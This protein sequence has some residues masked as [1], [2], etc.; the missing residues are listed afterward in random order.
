[1]SHLHPDT[2]ASIALL[3]KRFYA[4]VT[5]PHTWRM[6]FLRYFT[7]QSFRESSHPVASSD[8]SVL[9][10][11]R[12]DTRHFCR[13]TA[14]A[15]WRSEYILRT[16]LLRSLARGK[17]DLT[18]G[19]NTPSPGGN[20]ASGRKQ[21]AI[22]TYSSRLPGLV[23]NIH[24]VF[25]TGKKSPRAILG[26]SSIGAATLS[27]PSSGKT[28]KWVL[29]PPVAG[30]Q[31]I[32]QFPHVVPYGV[33]TG[34]A[35]SPNVMEVSLP[36]GMILGEGLPG[37]RAFFRAINGASGRYLGVG[38][39]I[40]N[41]CPAIP[42]VPQALEA[43]S[44]LWLAKSNAVPAATLSMC[45]IFTGSTLGIVTA[46]ALDGGDS[47]GPRKYGDGDMSARWLLSPGVPI[48]ALQVDEEYSWKR[49][50]SSRVWAVALNALGEVYYLTESPN[51]AAPSAGRLHPT[52][53][54]KQAWCAGQSAGWRLVE[55]TRR[56]SRLASG[57]DGLDDGSNSSSSRPRPSPSGHSKPGLEQ[58]APEAG[59]AEELLRLPPAYFR[60]RFLGWD[61]QRRLE[62][63]FA[64]GDDVGA[65]EAVFVVD[66]G[67]AGDQPA[68]IRRFTRLP[69][70]APDDSSNS[71]RGLPSGE[72]PISSDP[73][74]AQPMSSS[75]PA[76]ACHHP[77]PEKARHRQRA[78]VPAW[79]CRP[80]A[81]LGKHSGAVISATG[82]DRS[83]QSLLT[84]AEDPL[85]VPSTADSASQLGEI[86]GRRGR[87]VA[88]GTSTGAV[89]IWNG[90]DCDGPD[91][92]INPLRIIQTDS[93][94]VSCLSLSALYLVHGGSDGLL[95]AWD[96]L[97]SSLEPIRT[98]HARPRG[99][100]ARPSSAGN[101]HVRVGAIW[102]DADATQL[103]GVATVGPL[104]RYW[105]FGSSSTAP[106]RRRRLRHGLLHGR[107]VS[108]RSGGAVAD[109]I[110]AEEAEL[111][112]E[113][114]QRSRDRRR[115]QS[116]FGVGALGD[117]TDDEALLYAQMVSHEAY[118]RD[119]RRRAQVS[120]PEPS[121]PPAA[122][123]AVGPSD[124]PPPPPPPNTT[125]D[126]DEDED[127][128]DEV[129]VEDSFERQLQHAIRLSLLDADA[130]PDPGASAGSGVLS[131]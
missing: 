63:D 86:P 129:E 131:P 69:T 96:P 81:L 121:S 75:P 15:T 85:Q 47:G 59:E 57:Q 41:P 89:L 73:S 1:M 70:A 114:E 64:A 84:P 21:A 108:R 46:Y 37:G 13:L 29:E 92:T 90:R 124:P 27:D 117:L 91:D 93:P 130:Q 68:R 65:G 83:S 40:V 44:C 116:R 48:V 99:R 10:P 77:D 61:M 52:E 31:S 50:T 128:V 9:S 98:L 2:H 45:G 71:T 74:A 20:N 4:L 38:D 87:L 36:Y 35:A 111:R 109:Y 104:V 6:A 14:L 113:D 94:S 78:D 39:D 23:T 32:D 67:L 123:M 54:L 80:L 72:P 120:S 118:L 106:G 24:A 66:C 30:A 115:L 26:A 122:P 25:S 3:S 5:T 110:A 19:S 22:L 7:G 97:A 125:D 42:K 33:G 18:H 101:D 55:A 49:R 103:R 107:P 56:I 34:P 28:D 12:P 105:A 126:E 43:I 95:Q 102:L 119:E 100:A 127:E 58:A 76:A 8:T 51:P 112:R 62:V 88:A 53:A 79:D 11:V 82:I 60:E 16:R 17:P